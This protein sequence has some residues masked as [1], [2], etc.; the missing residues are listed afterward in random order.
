MKVFILYQSDVWKNRH[1]R[2]FYGV[3]KTQK[4]A[5]E[6]AKVNELYN[7]ITEVEIVEVTLNEFVDSLL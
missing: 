5:I 2:V 7:C 4:K 1:S 3:F 6:C